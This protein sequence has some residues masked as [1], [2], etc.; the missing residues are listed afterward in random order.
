[1]IYGTVAP[2]SSVGNN[3][4]TYINKTT[5]MLYGPKAAG[6]WP[7]GVSLV[8]ATGA[9]GA[10][11]AAGVD[12]NTILNGTLTPA[13]SKGVTGDFYINTNTWTIYGPKASGVWSG[14]AQS[15]IG[16]TGATGATGAKGDTGAQGPQGATGPAGTQMIYGTTAPASGT[17]NNG[18]TYINTN[19]SMLYGPKAA[20]AW[21]TGVSLIGPT[22]AAGTPGT[23]GD[24]GAQGP[25]GPTG[26]QGP[27]GGS[28]SPQSALP[29]PVGRWSVPIFNNTTAHTAVSWSVNYNR[30]TPIL[31]ETGAPYDRI[32]V[33]F[34]SAF[35]GQARLA[36]YNYD[37][38][39]PLGVGT[40]A[41]DCGAVNAPAAGAVVMS[42]NWTPPALSSGQYWFALLPTGGTYYIG[43]SLLATTVPN[44]IGIGSGDVF[45][46]TALNYASVTLPIETNQT[47]SYT[48][49][50]P[51]TLAKATEANFAFGTYAMTV[52]MRKS[53]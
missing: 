41:L 6:A 18:D 15:L 28:V 14:T 20:G 51:S 29:S 47:N 2:T 39:M 16:P 31:V 1:M 25:V 38:T 3:G 37:P 13:T 36:I 48:Q 22:G 24:I 33:R 5:S 43:G 52:Y 40:L 8:G 35:G 27:A 42:I 26:P 30:L 21:P 44:A 50:A 17:G 45:P 7:T 4:D 9:T 10:T 23:K 34:T 11:G 32:G 49:A 12:G 46:T 53:A 19:T